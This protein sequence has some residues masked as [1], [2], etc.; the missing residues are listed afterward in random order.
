V[1]A[2]FLFVIGQ[3]MYAKRYLVRLRNLIASS[4]SL[5]G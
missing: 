1:V 3:L 2:V 5:L 4:N